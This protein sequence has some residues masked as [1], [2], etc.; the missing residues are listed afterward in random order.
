[1]LFRSLVSTWISTQTVRTKT[2]IHIAPYKLFTIIGVVL[3]LLFFMW[4]N[5]MSYGN[6]LQFS[7][8]VPTASSIGPDGKPATPPSF[9]VRNA[10]EYLN[11]EKQK[12]SAVHFFQARNLVNG[13]FIHLFSPDR[14]IL[15]FTPVMIFALLG[16]IVMGNKQKRLLQLLLGIIAADI[17]LYSLWGDPWGGWAFGSRYLIPAYAIAAILIGAA[18]Q[19][20]RKNAIVL[21]LFS[22]TLIYSVGVNTLGALT[23]NANP[24]KT[25]VLALEQQTGK[26]EK[27]T[28]ARNYDAV[29]ANNSKSFVFQ[30]IGE[31]YITAMQFYILLSVIILLPALGVLFYNALKPS[32]YEN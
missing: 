13:L 25:Q 27:Y 16:G 15:Y 28:V 5:K 11:P 29:L 10:D 22:L 7:G 9:S 21:I 6:P 2:T 23:S 3:P 32:H 18:L 31:K 26:Q 24:P 17:T 14:G 12:R 19:H 1:M 30:T 8:T 20:Y 4:F